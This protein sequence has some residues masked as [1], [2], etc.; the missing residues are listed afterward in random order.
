MPPSVYSLY[1]TVCPCKTWP[2]ESQVSEAFPFKM[3]S[4]HSVLL[5]ELVDRPLEPAV[6]L[7]WEGP[8]WKSFFEGGEAS[9]SHTHGQGD[10]PPP[11]FD[12]D[13]GVISRSCKRARVDSPKDWSQVVKLIPDLSWQESR[14]ADFQVA[15]RRWLDAL[16]RMPHNI[17]ICEQLQGVDDVSSQLRVLRDVFSRKSPAT[18]KKRINSL[19]RYMV[20]LERQGVVFPGNEQ[21]L[22]LFLDGERNQGAPQSKLQG[23]I[24]SLNFCQHVIG[25]EEVS[26]L[27]SS[28]RCL[29]VPGG[30]AGGPRRQ[31]DPFKV[32]EMKA[33]HNCLDD[34]DNDVW[35]RMMAGATLFCIYSRMRWNDFQHGL[36]LIVDKGLDGEPM[37]LEM[38]IQEHKTKHSTAFRDHYMHAVAP[39]KGVVADHWIKNWMAVRESLGISFNSKYPT[40][41]APG[42]DSSPTLRPLTTGEM[43]A[44]V[45]LILEREGIELSG[46]GISSHSCKTTLL[47]WLAKRGDSYEDRLAL[48][49][50]VSFMKSCV[51]YSRDNL[52][53]PLRILESLLEEVRLGVFRPDES[54]SGRFVEVSESKPSAALDTEL[55][56][57]VIDLCSDSD[58]EVKTIALKDE[59]SDHE[60]EDDVVTTS[61][62]SDEEAGQL[63]GAR[64]PVNPPRIP[65]GLKLIQHQKLKT[66]H[67][68]ENQNTKIL[69]CGRMA[70]ESGYQRVFEITFDTPCC[71]FC[72]RKKGDY[73][74]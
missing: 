20:F 23:V 43:A 28:K 64:R 50:H 32:L 54:R 67:L 4:L 41:P 52:S 9:G 65:D 49:G 51:T 1:S 38:H 59:I 44:W 30:K 45:K 15:L 63:S 36:N 21:F 74:A 17:E 10:L 40:M 56:E 27:T 69:L 8:F 57:G 35:D 6:I 60:P 13:D 55:M 68:M 25:I 70:P 37:Y 11:V 46:R 29:G 14:D 16:L 58:V 12:P 47:S 39:A 7:P 24:E 31:A 3:T 18:L 26:P 42:A 62:S 5:R 66:L 73:E 19:L 71:H 33:L 2:Q 34:V 61:S 72:W 53:R 22:Y 48:G